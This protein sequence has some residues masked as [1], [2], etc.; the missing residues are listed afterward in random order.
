MA[1]IK[2]IILKATDRAAAIIRE[3]DQQAV[4]IKAIIIKAIILKATDRVAAVIRAADLDRAAETTL[5]DLDRVLVVI[6]TDRVKEAITTDQ[7]KE[8]VLAQAEAS[9]LLQ[10]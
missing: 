2:V 3:I 10:R 8:D 9:M 4:A 7:V 6:I 5:A 1:A